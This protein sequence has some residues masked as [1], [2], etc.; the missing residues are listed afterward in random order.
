MSRSQIFLSNATCAPLHRGGGGS[1]KNDDAEMEW[2]TP[3]GVTVATL[4][5]D[6]K[7]GVAQLAAMYDLAVG[8]DGLDAL[9][10]AGSLE[11]T[12]AHVQV[13]ARVVPEQKERVVRALRSRGLATMMCGDGTNDVGALKAA[14]AGIALLAAV[15]GDEIGGGGEGGGGGGRHERK[16]GKRDKKGGSKRGEKGS[17]GGGALEALDAATTPEERIKALVKQMEAADDRTA[18]G[19]LAVSVRPGDAS[20]AA[21]FTARSSGVAPCVDVIRQG[22][23]ALVTT[24]QMFKILGGTVHV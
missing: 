23:A 10:R 12:V 20:L 7:R 18:G 22:R 5:T 4:G 21:P 8:G 16:G 2:Q 24:L 6:P 3:E 11:A 17:G 14:H 15:G 19:R 9:S 1:H 13:Y